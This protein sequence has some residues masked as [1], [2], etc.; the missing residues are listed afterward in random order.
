[1]V[2]DRWHILELERHERG[3]VR[4]CGINVCQEVE[5]AA[6]D[7]LAVLAQKGVAQVGVVGDVIK[8]EGTVEAWDEGRV[9]TAGQ[10]DACGTV[11]VA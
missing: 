11:L 6:P 2:A 8:V 4:D 3:H 9:P 10:T 5:G 1:M 7:I